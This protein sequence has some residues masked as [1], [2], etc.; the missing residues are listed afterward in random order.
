[1]NTYQE[2]IKST[3]KDLN[4]L[5]EETDNIL[6]SLLIE[7]E[8]VIN[9]INLKNNTV[10][11]SSDNSRNLNNSTHE[12]KLKVKINSLARKINR[13]KDKKL[14][15]IQ[16]WSQSNLSKTNICPFCYQKILTS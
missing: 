13:L 2:W 6:K 16:K 5:I 7:D 14:K 12:K 9:K 15:K 10:K 11:K 3:E 4:I 1:M 8:S